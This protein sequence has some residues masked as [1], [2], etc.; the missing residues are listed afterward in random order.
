MQ[1]WL[2]AGNPAGRAAFRGAASQLVGRSLRVTPDAPL[3]VMEGVA[4][5]LLALSAIIEADLVAGRDAIR[6]ATHLVDVLLVAKEAARPVG[7]AWSVL[8]PGAH[9]VGLGHGS[10]GIAWSLHRAAEVIDHRSQEVADVLDDVVAF[11]DATFDVGW[12]NWVDP[13]ATDDRPPLNTWCY[14]AAGVRLTRVGMGR[15]PPAG[16]AP[17]T[18]THSMLADHVCC[19]VAGRLE[20]AGAEGQDS[21]DVRMLTTALAGR[22]VD[23]S[24]RVECVTD[25]RDSTSMFRGLIGVGYSLLRIASPGRFP[26]VTLLA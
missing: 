9:T 6:A 17:L 4:G 13:R 19:G 25:P 12:G 16:C 22:V 23:G 8:A 11:E 10:S 2:L 5:A 14:G 15:R 24:A 21:P 3:D 20:V 7:I 1:T 26:S 18:D